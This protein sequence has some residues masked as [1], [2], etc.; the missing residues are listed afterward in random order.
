M[1][2]NNRIYMGI[3]KLIVAIYGFKTK[4]KLSAKVQSSKLQ[5]SPKK[6]IDLE[7]LKQSNLSGCINYDKL[8][9]AFLK[10]YNL[11]HSSLAGGKI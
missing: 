4:K 2:L 1:S 8:K 5:T 7:F 9:E 3:L 10:E 11:L 6:K